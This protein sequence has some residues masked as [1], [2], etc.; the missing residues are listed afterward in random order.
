ME[1]P[2]R[3]VVGNLAIF[4]IHSQVVL[5]R[6]ELEHIVEQLTTGQTSHTYIEVGTM[7]KHDTSREI[8]T[9]FQSIEINSS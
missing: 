7:R 2:T 4:M 3:L 8:N 5:L 6:N 1:Q 9:S